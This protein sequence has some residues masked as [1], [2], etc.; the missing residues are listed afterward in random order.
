MTDL[1][2]P[3]SHRNVH[4]PPGVCDSL[5]CAALGGLLLLLRLHLHF[6]IRISIL[7]SSIWMESPDVG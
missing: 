7:S 5:L 6:H 4:E 1:P 2:L 3:T